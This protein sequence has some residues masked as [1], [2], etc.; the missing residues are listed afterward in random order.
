[1]PPKLSPEQVRQL[2]ANFM[3]ECAEDLARKGVFSKGFRV[4]RD[5]LLQCFKR[6][7]QE[8]KRQLIAQ[9]A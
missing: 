5:A 3:R 1:M 9:G 6:K 7:W 2:N 4:R 8:Y